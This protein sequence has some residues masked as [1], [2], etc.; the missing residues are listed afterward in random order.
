[1]LL[2][3]KALRK[4]ASLIFESSINTHQTL[5]IIPMAFGVRLQGIE[6]PSG[7]KKTEIEPCL[8]PYNYS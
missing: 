2:R 3:Q 4:K 7:N 6:R 8:T 1:M 5:D